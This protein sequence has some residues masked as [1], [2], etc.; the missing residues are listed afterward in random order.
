MTELEL[1]N[2]F[3]NDYPSVLE[4]GGVRFPLALETQFTRYYHTGERNTGGHTISRFMDGSAL[5]TADELKCAWATW[6][7]EQKK[8]FCGA[9]A[10]LHKQGD[11][12]EMLRHIMQHGTSD[13]WAAIAESIALLLP[14]NE[15][16]AFLQEALHSTSL[17]TGA[18]FA[19][20][21]ATTKHPE[22]E[23]TLRLHLE[24]LLKCPTIWNDYESRNPFAFEATICIRSLIE[25]G[26]SA[27]DFEEAA[28]KLSNHL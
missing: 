15:A 25:I 24:A 3:G 11:F 20:A 6:A 21:I 9:S 14:C 22:A 28:R 18:N 17:G 26:A 1:K 4:K 8:D 23:L 13:H 2:A 5:I 19:Q 12:P 10:W 16:F 27:E 7:N